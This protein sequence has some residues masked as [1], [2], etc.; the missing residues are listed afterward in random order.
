VGG[1]CQP[2]LLG[3]A[4]AGGCWSLTL[5]DGQL[6]AASSTG[7]VENIRTYRLSPDTPSM[8]VELIK[9]MSQL[10][11]V[12]GGKLYWVPTN[13]GIIRYCTASNC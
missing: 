1:K 11:T 7:L 2:L 13:A 10:T 3:Q 12:I 8:P 9:G 5:S 6:Y 4:P